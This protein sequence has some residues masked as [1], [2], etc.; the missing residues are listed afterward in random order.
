VINNFDHKVI[1]DFYHDYYR[2]DLQAIIVVGDVDADSMEQK[3]ISQFSGIPAVEDPKPREYFEVP[4][5]KQ[6]IVGIITDPEESNLRFSLYFK[7]P[8]TPNTDKNLD[9]Y[10]SSVV[11]SLYS[12]M[13]GS[14]YNELVQTGTPPFIYAYAAYYNNVRLMDTYTVGSALKEDNILGGIEAAMKE[15]ERVLRHGFATTELERAKIA[16]LTA[17]ETAFKERNKRNSDKIVRELQGHYLKNEPIPG[18]EYEYE[19]IQK[20]LPGIAVEE[21]NSLA[22]K[23]NTEENMVVTVSGPE[24]DSLEYPSKAQIL[25]VLAKVKQLSVEPYVDKVSDEP[26]ISVLPAEGKVLI[27]KQLTDFDAIEWELENGAKVI[28][29]TTDFKENEIN[30]SAYSEG[31]NSL[32]GVEDLSSAQ[33]LGTFVNAFG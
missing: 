14:R 12:D 27:E 26:L 6:P 16:M 28:V 11:N 32:Y 2:T 29:K 17:Y 15:N 1:R 33:M 22:K 21:V 23:W 4:G 25:G 8:A 30:L 3:I 24:K 31:G 13:L 9:Y 5:N 19:L 7:H 20:L 18:I 10:R